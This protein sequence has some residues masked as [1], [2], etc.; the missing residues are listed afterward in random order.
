[1]TYKPLGKKFDC[2]HCKTEMD[3]CP[4]TI[5]VGRDGETKCPRCSINLTVIPDTNCA[6]HCVKCTNKKCVLLKM[7][8]SED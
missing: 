5:Q 7:V 8:E 1:M 6:A 4:T 3:V 2:P